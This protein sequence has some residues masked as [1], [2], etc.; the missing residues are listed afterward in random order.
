METLSHLGTSE[1]NL[2]RDEDEQN[3]LGLEHTVDK[4]REELVGID[5]NRLKVKWEG[6]LTSGS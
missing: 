3:N 6:Q 5:K 2:A 1:D 4:T